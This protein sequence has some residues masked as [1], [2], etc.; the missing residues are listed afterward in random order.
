MAGGVSISGC[1]ILRWYTLVPR[2]FAAS[3]NGT[4]FLMGDAGICSPR[5]LMDNIG[6]K[7]GAGLHLLVFGL[8]KET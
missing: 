1:P 7:I 6:T 8:K 2:F 4:N 5:V 3:A